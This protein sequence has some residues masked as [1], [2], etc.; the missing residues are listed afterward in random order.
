MGFVAEALEIADVNLADE[1]Q[2]SLWWL[3]HV[4]VEHRPVVLQ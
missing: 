3:L 4:L 2:Q 1:R